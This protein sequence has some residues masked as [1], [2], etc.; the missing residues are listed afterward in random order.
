VVDGS[1]QGVG[2]GIA[3]L[4]GIG[5]A[6]AQNV[7]LLIDVLSWNA[8]PC[9]FRHIPASFCWQLDCLPAPYST[10]LYSHPPC[11]LV[12]LHWPALLLL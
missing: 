10:S 5:A 11:R 1:R 3:L 2:R 6:F 12:Q 7:N 9:W 8:L 4:G